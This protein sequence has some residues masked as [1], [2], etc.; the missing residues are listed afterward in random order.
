MGTFDDCCDDDCCRCGRCSDFWWCLLCVAIIVA[1]ALIVVLVVAFG[2]VRHAEVTVDDASLTR[3]ALATAPTTAFAYNLTV[4]LTVR[5]RNWAMAM[6]NTKPLDAAYKF[7]DQPFDRVRLAGDG[8]KH[9][10]GKTRVYRLTSG[11]DSA[12]V[13]LG[14]AGVAEF[15]K[16][17]ATGTFEVEVA[18]TGEVKYTARVTK[19]KI[20][21]SCPLKL[22]LAP[23]GQAPAALVFQKVKCKLAK[24]EKNC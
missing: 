1:I 23:P 10:A 6:T 18:V 13:A 17:N 15:R 20:E 12:Y 24:A 21:A 5:N 3:L 2:F 19:C 16:Q 8:D 4:T 14:N 9:A 22:Q 11:A 7:D